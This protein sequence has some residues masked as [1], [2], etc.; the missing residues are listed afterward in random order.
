[1]TGISRR[2]CLGAL[3]FASQITPAWA[4]TAFPRAAI[5]DWGLTT[6]VLSLGI[7]PAGIA[8]IELYHRWADD[9][10]IPAS[11]QDVGL[12]TEPNL[13]VL[14]ALKPDAILTTPFSESV[15]P[16][17]ERIAPTRSFATYTPAG[18][19]LN[20]SMQVLREVA[21][22]LKAEQQAE[23][24]IARVEETFASLRRS[25]EGR[26]VPPLLL[27]GFMDSRHTRIYGQESL[28]GNVLDRLGLQNAWKIPTNFW[29]FSLVGTHELAPYPDAKLFAIEPIPADAPLSRSGSGLW[30]SLPFVRAGRVATLPTCWAFGDVSTAMRFARS[31]TKAILSPEGGHAS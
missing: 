29:G 12:R 24:V 13:E 14:A 2:E 31:L 18:Q 11:V 4:Q 3:L 26:S 15:R 30:Q 25:L 23:N 16:M 28:F 27:A 6:S 17:L 20:R 10:P 7:V 1:M 5:L 19:P 21:A 9:F 22:V 8:E